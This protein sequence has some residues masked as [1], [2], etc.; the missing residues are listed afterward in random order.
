MK[1][2][3]ANR[4]G[5]R[6]RVARFG[7]MEEAAKIGERLSVDQFDFA[8]LYLVLHSPALEEPAWLG[9]LG[10][11]ATVGHGQGLPV[12]PFRGE[13]VRWI[14]AQPSFQHRITASQTLIFNLL[15]RQVPAWLNLPGLRAMQ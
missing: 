10:N 8:G 2:L 9:Q 6:A 7:R 4:T 5:V 13:P 11:A 1:W 12:D 15:A 14:S 3:Q